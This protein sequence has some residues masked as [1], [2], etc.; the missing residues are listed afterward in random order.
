VTGFSGSDAFLWTPTTPNGNIG[1]AIF[2]GGLG[3][4]LSSGSGINAGGQVTGESRT[5]EDTYHAFLY[6]GTLHDIGT[7]GGTYSAGYG[8]NAGGQVTGES[9]TPGDAAYVAFLYTS[10]SGMVDLN[11]LIDPL[12]GWKLGI[13][14]AINDAGQIT[15]YGYIND[16]IHAFLLTPVPEPAS[17][18]LL[19]LG[20]PLLVWRNSR[21]LGTGGV[22]GVRRF[23]LAAATRAVTVARSDQ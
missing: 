15:G 22:Q 8:I 2:L 23:A 14:R 17:V 6:D 11:T 12:S 10:G 9:S 1:T 13:G 18:A 3:G 7:L 4:F 21:Q 19:A 20:L 16:Y 5:T